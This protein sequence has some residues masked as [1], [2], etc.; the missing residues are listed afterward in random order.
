[1]PEENQEVLRA[2]FESGSAKDDIP[3]LK[4]SAER[5]ELTKLAIYLTRLIKK[6]VKK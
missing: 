4:N 3:K 1:M 5:S 6:K 2:C